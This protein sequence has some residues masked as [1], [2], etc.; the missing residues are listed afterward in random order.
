MQR[1]TTASHARS[2]CGRKTATGN[3]GLHRSHNT[4]HSEESSVRKARL[5]VKRIALLSSAAHQLHRERGQ[6]SS[7]EWYSSSSIVL[8]SCSAASCI[9]KM[10]TK[11]GRCGWDVEAGE[12][13]FVRATL[14]NRE[15]RLCS[16]RVR[17]AYLGVGVAL[18]PASLCIR[19]APVQHATFGPHSRSS[20][21]TMPHPGTRTAASG[22]GLWCGA[23]GSAS[24]R[25][26]TAGGVQP[27]G[28]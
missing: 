6:A 9:Y 13:T 8:Y 14:C 11:W 27:A 1:A 28:C 21:H 25:F 17:A 24:V 20:L 3:R 5:P 15:G 2:P 26:Q 19:D 7:Q 12:R 16:V 10:G 22:L 4:E 23:H 18:H